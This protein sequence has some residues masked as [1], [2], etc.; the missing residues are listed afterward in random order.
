[1][2]NAPHPLAWLREIWAGFVVE[3]AMSCRIGG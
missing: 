2:R 1:M 3:V